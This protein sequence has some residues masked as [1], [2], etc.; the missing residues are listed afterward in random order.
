MDPGTRLVPCTRGFF[1]AGV[2][3]WRETNALSIGLRCGR[4]PWNAERLLLLL[5]PV[6][7]TLPVRPAPLCTM[8]TSG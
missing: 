7:S 1:G 6:L 3:L 8:C 5:S 2:A 4:Y